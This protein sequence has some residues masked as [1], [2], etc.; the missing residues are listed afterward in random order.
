ME[1]FIQDYLKKWDFSWNRDG[2]AEDPAVHTRL[3][4]QAGAAEGTAGVGCSVGA[5][6]AGL[7]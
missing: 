4:V 5:V 2:G 6:G 3:Q 1:L 7:K